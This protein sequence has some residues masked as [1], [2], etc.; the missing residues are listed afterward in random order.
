MTFTDGLAVSAIV[1]ALLAIGSEILFFIVQ[2]DRAAKSQREISDYVGQMRQVL[3][4][5]EGLTT[6]TGSRLETITAQLVSGLLGRVGPSPEAVGAAAGGPEAEVE[7]GR[8]EQIAK[9]VRALGPARAVLEYLAG[10]SR[11]AD[12]LGS[13]LVELKPEGEGDTW[14]WGIPAAV[15]VLRALDLL[16]VDRENRTVSLTAEGRRFAERLAQETHD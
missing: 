9:V 6:S 15:G 14:L 16:T 2:T 5:I 12:T 3:G 1:L 8:L 4:K 11:D 7:Q 10:G 13:Q